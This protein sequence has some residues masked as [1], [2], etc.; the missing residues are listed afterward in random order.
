LIAAGAMVPP[1]KVIPDGSV[2]MG[3]PGKIVREISERDRAMIEGIAKH[4]VAR[5]Q[6]YRQELT[7]DPRNRQIPTSP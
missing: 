7:L 2:V 3:M 1:G 5:G 4:Y 6:L